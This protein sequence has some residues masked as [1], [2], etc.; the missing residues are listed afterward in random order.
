MSENP[1]ASLLCMKYQKNNKTEY[2]RHLHV[3]E[4]CGLSAMHELQIIR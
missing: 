2:I 4:F 1:A 3:G